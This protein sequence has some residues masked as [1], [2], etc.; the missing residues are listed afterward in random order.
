ML[1]QLNT[2]NTALPSRCR[3]QFS[4][5]SQPSSSQ[6]LN[7]AMNK[8]CLE[9]QSSQP[10]PLH[11][12]PDVLPSQL[13]SQMASQDFVPGSQ[14]YITPADPQNEAA[15]QRAHFRSP[16]RLSPNR[17]KRPRNVL[18]APDSMD[19]SQSQDAPR[20]APAAE[21]GAGLPRKLARARMPSPPCARNIFMDG[22]EDE[23]NEATQLTRRPPYVS[24]YRQEFQEIASIGQGNFSKVFRVKSKFDGMEYAL[25]RSF[26]AVASE[27]EAKRWQQEAMAMAASGAHPNVVRYYSAWTERQAEG[28]YFYILMEKCEVSL[29]TKHLLDGQP[30]RE[31]ELLDILRQIG[32]A[33][34]HLHSLGIM[35]MDVKPDNIYTTSAGTYKLGDFGLATTRGSSGHAQLQE[36]DSRYIPQEILNDDFSALDKANVFM[37]GASLYELASGAQLPTGGSLYHELRQGKLMLMPSFTSGFQKMLR[38][39][40]AP[41]PRDRPSAARV[42]TSSLLQ[43][44]A[45]QRDNSRENYGA[46]PLQPIVQGK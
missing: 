8:C 7:S 43:R 27:L 22:P 33:L 29:G 18:G 39:L 13:P 26:R 45:H 42:L 20:A 30:F 1:G 31:D 2:C 9:S 38:W 15:S 11:E 28:Q 3:L 40:M 36:G 6:F 35:H 44:K 24:R 17:I 34:Q 4:Q 16:A 25:K 19:L 46:L 21:D 23:P 12:E 32:E 14:D 41:A 5:G 37:L 10:T